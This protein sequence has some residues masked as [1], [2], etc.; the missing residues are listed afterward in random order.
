V[1]E[2]GAADTELVADFIAA[3]STRTSYLRFFRPIACSHAWAEALRVTRGDP[4]MRA[5]R[6]AIAETNGARRVVALA[7][8]AH[9]AAA[10]H[11]AEFALVIHDDYQHEGL[12]KSV[13]ALL[14]E[15]ARL[16]GIAT[17]CGTALA[18]NL[19]VRRLLRGMAVPYRAQT[20]QGETSFLMDLGAT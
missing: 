11:S 6:V 8:L 16:R 3:L 1:R 5:A 10:Q 4:N 15:L 19:V 12:G 14:F 17:L 7:E 9:D 20:S 2:A 13:L 18:E